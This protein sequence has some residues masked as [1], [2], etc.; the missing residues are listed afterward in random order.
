MFLSAKSQ[1]NEKHADGLEVPCVPCISSLRG[2]SATP[3]LQP[4]GYLACVVDLAS[5]NIKLC[6]HPACIGGLSFIKCWRLR[7]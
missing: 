3:F 2:M 5:I 6:G 1:E 7:E 4:C